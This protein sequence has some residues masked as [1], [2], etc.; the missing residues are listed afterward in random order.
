MNYRLYT[1][2][3]NHYLS[4]LQCGLQTAHVVAEISRAP[5][6]NGFIPAT[7]YTQ[8]ADNDKTIIICGAGN[9]QGVLEC[10]AELKRTV[11]DTGIMSGAIFYEDERSMN[12]MATACGVIVPERFWGAVFESRL[13]T[14]LEDRWVYAEKNPETDE[15]K[16]LYVYGLNTPIGKFITHIKKYRLA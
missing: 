7:A 4:P 11:I 16:N 6:H 5:G 14:G 9:H 10:W 8:W 12:R 1:F 15:V 2:V 13:D 3:A